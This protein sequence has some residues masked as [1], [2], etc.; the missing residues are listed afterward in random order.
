MVSKHCSSNYEVNYIVGSL[1]ENIVY[2]EPPKNYRYLKSE[3]TK[4]VTTV[5]HKTDFN[6]EF[7]LLT[8]L[9]N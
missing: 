2:F 6:P 7:L 9:T 5:F 1:S 8:G 4:K 3:N